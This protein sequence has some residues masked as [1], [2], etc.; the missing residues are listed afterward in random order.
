MITREDLKTYAR[1]KKELVNHDKSVQTE[2]S[3][4]ES[5]A[6]PIIIL[7]PPPSRKRYRDEYYDDGEDEGEEGEYEEDEYEDEYEEDECEESGSGSD[8]EIKEDKHKQAV[9]KYNKDEIKYYKSLGEEEKTTID[10]LENDISLMDSNLIPLRFKVLQSNMETRI[11]ALAI[12]Y[13]DQLSSMSKSS[14]EYSKLNHYIQNLCKI[15]IGKYQKM[16]ISTSDTLEEISSFLE[17]TK[18]KL[19]KVVYGHEEAKNQMI[20]L[21]AKWIS[22]PDA[23]GLVIGIE[24]PM[25]AGKTTLCKEGICNVLGIPF[26]F[27]TLGGINDSS[28]LIGMNY[29]YEGSRWGSIV[30]TLINAKCMN[31]VLFFDELDKISDT[32]K[33]EEIVNIL[34]HLTDSTQNDKFHDEYYANIDFDLSKC[35][36]IFSYNDEELINPILKDRMVTIRTNGYTLKEKLVIAKDYMLPVILT[37]FKFKDKD[38]VFDDE[39]LTYMISNLEEEKGVRNLKRG[40]EDIVS[41]LNLQRLLRNTE[42]T[43]P[44]KITQSIADK[45]L[46]KPK[47]KD[48]WVMQAMY[49]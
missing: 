13:I 15:P 45:F 35:L 36:I 8:L 41:H 4:L 49:L 9:E 40:L 14:G 29:T 26:G 24:G 42:F 18:K 44:L 47:K 3:L 6:Y 16:N 46:S 27:I 10:K 38:I 39:I 28:S 22:N 23:G 20:R 1:V 2:G 12:S 17:T 31:P 19:D 25:G 21:L 33:G 32:R 37:T 34:I 43:F 30:N 7:P 48:D 11:K 5:S